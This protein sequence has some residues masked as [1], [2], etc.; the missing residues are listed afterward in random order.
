MP[1]V[2]QEHFKGGMD[3]EYNQGEVPEFIGHMLSPESQ[4]LDRQSQS[5]AL[6]LCRATLLIS[7][8][9]AVCEAGGGSAE[10]RAAVL[11]E[12]QRSISELYQKVREACVD[13]ASEAVKPAPDVGDEEWE[14]CRHELLGLHEHQFPS[15]QGL[16]RSW[17]QWL[18]KVL[19]GG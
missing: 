6:A 13:G 1:C 7:K 18:R 14:Q 16:L 8:P 4:G 2:L 5:G 11:S 10:S 9:S 17:L 3:F 19:R 12:V 15:D